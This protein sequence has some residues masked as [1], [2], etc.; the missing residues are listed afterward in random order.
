MVDVGVHVKRIASDLRETLESK[1]ELYSATWEHFSADPKPVDMVC[2]ERQSRGLD[3]WSTLANVQ[4]QG[5]QEDHVLVP[6]HCRVPRNE[7]V[8]A[9]LGEANVRALADERNMGCISGTRES[10]RRGNPR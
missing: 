2:E 6:K 9:R 10:H 4:R 1:A 8:V 7:A 5:N 3:V